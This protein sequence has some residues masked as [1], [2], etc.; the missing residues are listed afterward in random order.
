MYVDDLA[1]ILRRRSLFED[2]FQRLYFK[3][4]IGLGQKIDCWS[5]VLTWWLVR[6][7]LLIQSIRIYPNGHVKLG[8]DYLCNGPLG[9]DYNCTVFM[10]LQL[11]PH[12]FS[13]EMGREVALLRLA[14]YIVR[15]VV[16]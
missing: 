7:D 2:W 3:N 8:S 16:G 14:N 13:Y 15:Q 1:I 12:F 11:A 4:R 10:L 9:S 6:E 5:S